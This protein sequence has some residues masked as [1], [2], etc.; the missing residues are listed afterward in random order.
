MILREAV[1]LLLI[2]LAI[3][4]VLALVALN[5][6]A[7]LLFG[8]SPRDPLS[9]VGAIALLS[10]AA[11]LAGYIPARKASRLEPMAALREE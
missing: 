7:K 10:L 9:F 8:L 5:V 4:T 3:G 11:L 2:G 6:S 1:S